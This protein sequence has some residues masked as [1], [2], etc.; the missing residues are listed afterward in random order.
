MH[1]VAI[2]QPT[3]LPWIGY[4]SLIKNVDTFVFLDSV[5]FNKRSWQQRN[6]IKTITGSK[7]LTVPILSKGKREQLIKDTIIN[8]ES[9]FCKE[10]IK[11]IEYNYCKANYFKSESKDLFNI[12][13]SHSN[14]IADLNIEIISYLSE[15]LKIKTN[16]IRSRDLDCKGSKADLLASI[17]SILNA[18]EYISPP[19]SKDYLEVSDAFKD[20]DTNVNYFEFKH[21][22]YEQLW[23]EFLPYMSIVDLLFNC[24]DNAINYI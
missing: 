18:K 10:H 24:G 21:P 16:F 9:N 14:Y 3:Y 15:R 19:G 2:M 5:Q 7:W 20:I 17:C 13:R 1:K 4:F 22:I 12:L 8:N 6:Q 23:G 11:T